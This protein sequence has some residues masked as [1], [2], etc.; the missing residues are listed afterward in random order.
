MILRD[1]RRATVATISAAPIPRSAAFVREHYAVK[2][3]LRGIVQSQAFLGSVHLANLEA[4]EPPRRLDVHL[5]EVE[6]SDGSIVKY[7][8]NRFDL[9]SEDWKQRVPLTE[10]FKGQFRRSTVI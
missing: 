5:I 4:V 8:G 2:L 10:D 3:E 1:G 9:Y 6:L 7:F